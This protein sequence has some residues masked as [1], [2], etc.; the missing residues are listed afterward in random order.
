MKGSVLEECVCPV[1]LWGELAVIRGLDPKPLLKHYCAK[2]SAIYVK[3]VKK[4][5]K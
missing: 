4:L 5:L 3:E 1:K 2:C